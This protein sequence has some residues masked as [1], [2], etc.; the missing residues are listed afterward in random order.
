MIDLWS[1]LSRAENKRGGFYIH[2]PSNSGKSDVFNALPDL[3]V[4]V[5]SL[6]PLKGYTFNWNDCFD[7]QLIVGEE[8]TFDKDDKHTIE[9][10]KELLSGNNVKLNKKHGHP[11]LC[12]AMPMLFI[13]NHQPFVPDEET[14]ENPWTSRLYE[15]ETKV[16]D[17]LWNRSTLSLH[18][19]PSAWLFL[20]QAY[21]FLD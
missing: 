18:I 7:K 3:F 19:D 10:L 9:T 16:A 17:A 13:T 12:Y 2:G 4:C 1:W 21:K 6:K 14:G 8:F 11:R 20:F 15:Y 5:G